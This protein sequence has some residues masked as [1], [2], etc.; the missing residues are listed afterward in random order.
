MQLVFPPVKF[1]WQLV[2]HQDF[3]QVAFSDIL[4]GLPRMGTAK[5]GLWLRYL[6]HFNKAWKLRCYSLQLPIKYLGKKQ[7]KHNN[8]C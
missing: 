6:L 1:T 7:D 5:I 4:E 8:K 3:A 2:N